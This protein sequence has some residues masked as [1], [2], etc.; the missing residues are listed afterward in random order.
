MTFEELGIALRTEREKRNL[1]LEDAANKLKI[2]PRQLRALEEGDINALPHAAYARGFIRS[3]ANWLGWSMEEIQEALANL[4]GTPAQPSKKQEASYIEMPEKSEKSSH[5]SV[6]FLVILLLLAG[7]AYWGWE[8]GKLDWLVSMV[9][10]K[11]HTDVPLQSADT[12][13]AEKDANRALQSEA[14]LALSTNSEKENTQKN[15]TLPVPGNSPADLPQPVRAIAPDSNIN[16]NPSPS[17]NLI[18]K[19][20]TESES[21]RTE[22]AQEPATHKLVITAIEECWVHSNADKTDTRQFSLRKGD[23][24]AL[25]FTKNLELKLGNAGGVRLRYD[26]EDLPAPGSSGQVRTLVFPPKVA[27]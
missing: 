19:A 5:K 14:S 12:Y 18:E 6:I 15:Y 8:N 17:E 27:Q 3:Y 16:E 1:H 4:D 2:N 24:F 21:A 10:N 22:Q 13:I 7:G 25:T 26:G 20:V 9:K 23:T 11:G